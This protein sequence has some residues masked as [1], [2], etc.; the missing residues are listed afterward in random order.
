[1]KDG[2]FLKKVGSDGRKWAKEFVKI[3]NKKNINIDEGFMIGWFCNAIEAGRSHNEKKYSEKISRV[4]S[5][6]NRLAIGLAKMARLAG[7]NAGK[8]IDS[9]KKE[10]D[11][12]WRNVIYVDLPKGQQ[13]SWHI[14]DK[15]VGLLKGLTKYKGKWSGTHLGRSEDWTNQFNK[16]AKKIK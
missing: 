7:L 13:V 12:E 14:S 6:R 1:M 3:I 4:Y 16:K 2:D 9:E 5:E 11:P 15:E 10:W 8:G